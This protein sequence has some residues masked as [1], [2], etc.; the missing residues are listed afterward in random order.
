MNS[1]MKKQMNSHTLR[2]TADNQPTVMEKLLQVAR[3]RGFIVTG[4]TMFPEEKD[5]LS[6]ELSVKSDNSIE[7]LQ[8]Q[9]HKLIDI[10]SI[11]VNN[12]A[13][14]QNLA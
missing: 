6:I 10:N 5:Q 4:M 9:L 1:Q 14:K 13:T 3:Y 11:C 2:I 8:Y 12:N 7:H